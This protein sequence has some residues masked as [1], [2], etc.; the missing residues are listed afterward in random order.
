MSESLRIAIVGLGS[1]GSRHLNTLLSMG[2]QDVVAVEPRPMP[3]EERVPVIGELREMAGWGATHAI[4][5]SPPE[6]HYHHAKF[7]LDRG[8]PTFIEKPM[9]RTASEAR[10]LC[11]IA[12]MNKTVLAVGYMERAHRIVQEARQW[13]AE[14]G[15]GHAEFYCYWRAAEKTYPLR[16][17]GESSHVIDTALFVMGKAER[18]VRRGGAGVRA[19]ASIVHGSA[20]SEITMDM[21][22]EPRRRIQL[23]AAD[24]SFFSKDYGTTAEEWDA[25]YRE[26]LQA[27]LNGAPLCTGHDGLAVM[28]VIEHYQ[29]AGGVSRSAFRRTRSVPW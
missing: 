5:C 8:I 14:N 9:T 27:F 25:C 1:I 23:Y 20:V 28:E 10:T 6:W 24:G 4:I 11:T 2:Y 3:Q 22:A 29:T 16:I 12:H 21:D 19:H 17:I 26:E 15:A 18:A 7:F 13:A